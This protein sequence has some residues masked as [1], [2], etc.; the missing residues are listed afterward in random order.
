VG[1]EHEHHEEEYGNK[2]KRSSEEFAEGLDQP[3][4]AA[5]IAGVTRSTV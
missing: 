4:K 3:A 1:L 5:L 2:D